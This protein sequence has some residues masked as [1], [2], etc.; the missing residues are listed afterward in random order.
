VAKLVGGASVVG[1]W[2]CVQSD[3][4]DVGLPAIYDRGRNGEIAPPHALMGIRD[5]VEITQII[6]D[7]FQSE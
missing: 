4:I 5:I 6:L 3:V 2:L 1:G 7:R